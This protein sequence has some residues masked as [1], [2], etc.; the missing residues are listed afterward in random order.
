[1]FDK[2]LIANRGEIA[3]RIARTAR[4]MGIRTVGV[5]SE[6]DAGALHTRVVDEAVFIGPPPA[7]ES[8]LVIAK[9][10][11]AAQ[12]TG[13]QGIHPGYGF[14][15]ENAQF[16]EA[17]AGQG[18]R[19]IG[20]PAA[21]IRAMGSKSKAK[22]LM[23][24]AGV[25]VVPGY[26]GADQSMAVLR[27][28]ALRIGYPLLVKASAGGGGKGMRIVEN[29]AALDDAIASAQREA[30]ASFGDDRLLLERYLHNPRH[31]EIQLFF[32]RHGN[33]V[34]L[35]ERD[36][37]IQR[38]Y[39][40]VVEEA[41]APQLPD[42]LRQR[43]Y[44]AALAAGRAVN[45]EGAG[46][47]E[48]ITAAGMDGSYSDFFFMEMNTRL[49]VEHPVTELITG[50]DLV[51]WQLRVAAGET[52]PLTQ[53]AI[54]Q[55]GHA[56]EVRL[57]A[58]DPARGFL[59]AAG[60]IT[61]LRFPPEDEHFRVD[62]G[63]EA[64]DTISVHYD[65]MVA[66]LI[67][68]DTHRRAAV[69]RLRQKVA[70]THVGGLT[71]N[72]GFLARLLGHDDLAA[73]AVD[74]GFLDRFGDALAR[75]PKVDNFSLVLA[76]LALLAERLS[77]TRSN[78]LASAEPDSPWH[79]G[80]GWALNH[81]SSEQFTWTSAD[82]SHEVTVRYPDGGGYVI[83]VA[84]ESFACEFTVVT[85][86]M[87]RVTVAGH[88]QRLHY[89]AD[90][91]VITLH[92][93]DGPVVLTL[94]DPLRKIA[95]EQTDTG[96]LRAP[97]PGKIIACHVSAGERVSRGQTLLVL[98]AMK[99]EHAII[100]PHDGTVGEVRCGAGDSVDEGVELIVLQGS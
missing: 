75:Q 92:L 100:A 94:D 20:P 55:H 49:Q 60:S 45:Y 1:M 76:S 28:E 90:G 43:M 53:E 79:L 32:D 77:T 35:F 80:D 69:N 26:H 22:A 74:T 59:P 7:R 83:A 91:P 24:S 37:S 87:T 5:Y 99:M 8:Y 58:E 63:I 71:T 2:I 85:N 44:E 12:R 25:P 33:A 6:A 15:S 57:Y 72:S 29:E 84:D 13:A 17:C 48:M 65:P 21:A 3:C 39:Q 11:A 23:Q 54:A 64:G 18:I 30:K 86:G 51:E 96:Q 82:D 52:L 9:I 98:E 97:M 4:A 89:S 38:R 62:T 36:C 61:A 19:F 93:S 66:K 46:T 41:P 42:A 67:S 95:G 14:L 68:W 56:M 34:H 73:G 47:V 88:L 16:A 10:V 50:I 81:E 78:A 40:K 31:I 27:S 70:A